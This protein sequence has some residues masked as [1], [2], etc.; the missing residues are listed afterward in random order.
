MLR[1]CRSCP[2]P[3][4]VP[5]RGP[6]GLQILL[7]YQHWRLGVLCSFSSPS[8]QTCPLTY[9]RG[10]S[11]EYRAEIIMALETVVLSW[12]IL[13]LGGHFRLSQ[14]RGGE[15]YGHL[16]GRDQGCSQI[17]CNAQDRP[18]Q[19]KLS[20]NAMDEKSWYKLNG[21]ALVSLPGI[22]SVPTQMDCL[23]G[24]WGVTCHQ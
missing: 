5:G 8:Q 9:I 3:P 11:T 10:N 16:V 1:A 14:F 12:Q 6:A 21:L 23:S 20:A 4:S 13:L 17:S 22:W 15:C 19:Q 24:F 18:T 2:L 7:L